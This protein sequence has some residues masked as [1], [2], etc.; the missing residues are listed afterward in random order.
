MKEVGD[1]NVLKLILQA[2][3][4]ATRRVAGILDQYV[5]MYDE[6]SVPLDSKS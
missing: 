6:Y 1:A 4:A 2:V 3:P 5:H